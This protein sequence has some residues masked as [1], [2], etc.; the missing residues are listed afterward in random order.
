MRRLTLAALF[1]AL[2]LTGTAQAAG[3]FDGTVASVNATT[4]MLILADGRS[5]VFE[6]RDM[7][8][9]LLPG[10]PVSIGYSSDGQATRLVDPCL[11]GGRPVEGGGP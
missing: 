11:C 1:A 2:L 3:R 6:D 4:G 7:L 8:R 5:V 10:E 9:H